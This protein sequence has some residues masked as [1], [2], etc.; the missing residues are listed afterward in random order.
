MHLITSSEVSHVDFATYLII[1]EFVP[2]PRFV[3]S[4]LLKREDSVQPA[5]LPL[6]IPLILGHLILNLGGD[7]FIEKVFI[8][9]KFQ[10]F[11]VKFMEIFF[12]Y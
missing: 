9:V 10:V 11:C 4:D 6:L 1:P 5:Y 3:L 7:H 8:P 12:F 2:R